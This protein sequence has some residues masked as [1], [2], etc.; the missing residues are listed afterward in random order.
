MMEAMVWHTETWRREVKG[1]LSMRGW[2]AAM[3]S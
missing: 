3:G 1:S 2:G